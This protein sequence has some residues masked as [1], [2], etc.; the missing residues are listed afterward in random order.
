MNDAL[1]C[2]A[3][4]TGRK[5]PDMRDDW[6]DH[7]WVTANVQD[8]RCSICKKLV[9]EHSDAEKAACTEKRRELIP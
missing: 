3:N 6:P 9:K 2:W 8:S 1:I 7:V 5:I 4:A